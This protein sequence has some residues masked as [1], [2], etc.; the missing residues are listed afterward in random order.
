[1]I[2]IENIKRIEKTYW[3]FDSKTIQCI[4]VEQVNDDLILNS[5]SYT[6]DFDIGLGDIPLVIWLDRHKNKDNE[7]YRF[8]NNLIEATN[9]VDI[10]DLTN[11][12]RFIVMLQDYLVSIQSEIK[13][14]FF[15]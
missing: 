15:K 7:G 3:N 8:E 5:N 9:Y 4:R 2:T 14:N 6:F 13:R 1:M 10:K 12:N 11:Y